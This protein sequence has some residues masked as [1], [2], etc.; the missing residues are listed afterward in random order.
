MHLM[1]ALKGRYF[2]RCEAPRLCRGGSKSLT[3]AGVYG[4]RSPFCLSFDHG[5]INTSKASVIGIR[6]EIEIEIANSGKTDS[7]INPDCKP[8]SGRA[9]FHP[10]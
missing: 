7:G 3:D 5:S 4:D 2:I 6:I 8:D 1:P 9:L 10:L